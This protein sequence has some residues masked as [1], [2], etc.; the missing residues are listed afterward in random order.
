M[1]EQKTDLFCK[2]MSQNEEYKSQSLET[3]GCSFKQML[4][5]TNG[6]HTAYMSMKA[7][8]GL[9]YYK[10]DIIFRLGY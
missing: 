1:S 10:V 5:M 4:L 8:R 2:V 9:T 7:T 6:S 3:F